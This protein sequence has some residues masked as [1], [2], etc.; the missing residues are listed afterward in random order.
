MNN[1]FNSAQAIA[2]LNEA[3]SMINTWNSLQN[4]KANIQEHTLQ[5]LKTLLHHFLFDI[6]GLLEESENNNEKLNGVM[7]LVI[8][9][10]KDAR[11]KK[12]FAT[13]DK[14]RDA[15]QGVGI[16]LKDSKDGTSWQAE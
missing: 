12:D 3:A 7:E 4:K 2:E 8:D 5:R 13:S 10:R 6:F 1:D 14:I 15:L 11:G 16:Q 9:I